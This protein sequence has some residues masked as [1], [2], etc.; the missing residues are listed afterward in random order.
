MLKQRT[1][2]TSRYLNDRLKELVVPADQYKPFPAI[3]DRAGWEALPAEIRAAEVKRAEEYL[4]YEWPACKATDF[5]KFERTGNRTDYETPSFARRTALATLVLGECIENKGRFLDD[6]ING[7]WVICEESFWGV[8]AHNWVG[9][10]RRE[11]LPNTAD[12]YVDLFAGETAGLLAFTDYLLRTRLDA[13]TPLITQRIRREMKERIIDPFLYREDFWWMGF[14]PK[15]VNNWAPWCV[16]NC[17]TA[18]LLLEENPG[19][20]A[21]AVAKS[22]V[23]VDKFLSVYFDDGGC[24]EG[25]SYWN[26]AGGSL[27]DCLELL[28]GAT[29]GKIDVY[30]DSLVKEIGRYL[31]RS[32][33]GG[34][35][36]INFADGGARVNIDGNLVY[37]YGRRI[38][39]EKLAAL[40]ANAY[41]GQYHAHLAGVPLP[42]F[43]SPLR[44]LPAIFNASEILATSLEQP[45]V[46]DVYM[47]GIEVM[48][49]RPK[50][51]S[52]KG[53]FLAAKGGHNEESHN[54]NDVGNF[55]VYAD[56]KPVLI[57]VG[58]ET[59][60]QKT[61][62]PRR[63]EIWT[64]QSAYHQLPTVNGVQQMNGLDYKASG[65][66]YESGGTRSAFTLDIATAYPEA[67]GLAE[68]KRTF[69]YEREG[70][71][72]ITITDAYKLSQ[73]SADVV[74]SL[75][76]PMN[77]AIDPK[78]FVTLGDV[79]IAF[80]GDKLEATYERIAV[81]DARLLP[82]WGDHLFRI[83]L[84]TRRAAA[85]DKLTMTI[86]QK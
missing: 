34:D 60:T 4:N 36:F 29:N 8:N 32:Y 14:T 40:G 39:D 11:P 68:W 1:I 50:A 47:D 20:R 25:T 33:I 74:L 83:L 85:A 78:G 82:I 16:S 76:T 73:P 69:I 31:Y 70:K 3:D 5:M 15:R 24:D 37:V 7:I 27:L 49:A 9:S 13:V 53:L 44:L 26:R 45:F 71:P 79:V 58:V 43:R 77:P 18:A 56:A 52:P 6:I 19:R 86:M 67:A 30:D 2:L 46:Q 42:G 80:E 22:I 63:Y 61:F 59:Y 62:S 64:M 72:S 28:S 57:D 48:V 10:F 35:Y 55:V 54:H 23:I 66:A 38:G 12:R 17:L 75:M 21:Q 84:K 81:A 41:K 51:G 65:A